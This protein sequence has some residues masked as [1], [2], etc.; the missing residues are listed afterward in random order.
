MHVKKRQSISPQVG[1]TGGGGGVPKTRRR[2]RT[3]LAG[4]DKS[5]QRTASMRSVPRACTDSAREG[6]ASTVAD[7]QEGRDEAR[8]D[9]SCVQELQA[10]LKRATTTTR[11]PPPPSCAAASPTISCRRPHRQRWSGRE[12]CTSDGQLRRRGE[13]DTERDTH[14]LASSTS[15]SFLA[16]RFCSRWDASGDQPPAAPAPADPSPALPLPLSSAATLA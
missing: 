14:R 5:P 2:G 16:R 15:F 3:N 11:Q 10:G 4:C 9:A 13:R 7:R 8:I 12:A 6:G 1:E